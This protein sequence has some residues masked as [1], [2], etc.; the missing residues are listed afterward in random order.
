MINPG[1]LRHILYIYENTKTT[2]EYNADVETESLK[3]TLRAQLK[4]KSGT[5]TI[6]NEEIFN[7]QQLEFITYYRNI[8]DD[9][10]I[11]YNDKK[12]NILFIEE[13][14]FKEGLKIIVEKINE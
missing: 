2:D 8:S 4:Y 5:K 1:Q 13:I 11:K 12:Y 10:I 14:G 7:S 9:M 6:S 3:F